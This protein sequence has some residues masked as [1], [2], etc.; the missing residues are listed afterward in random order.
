MSGSLGSPET[1]MSAFID[2]NIPKRKATHKDAIY[3]YIVIPYISIQG[4]HIQLYSN[5][6]HSYIV[7]PYIVI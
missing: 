5:P 4:S 3:S 6:I 7:I 1:V 2:I